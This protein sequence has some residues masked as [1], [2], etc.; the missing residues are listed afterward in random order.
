MTDIFE[1]LQLSIQKLEIKVRTIESK[2]NTH[3]ELIVKDSEV[4]IVINSQ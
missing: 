4:Y 3:D 2:L 1:S